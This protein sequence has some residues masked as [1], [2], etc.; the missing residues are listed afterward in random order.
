[1]LSIPTA[2]KDNC[3]QEQMDGAQDDLLP[4]DMQDLSAHD[5]DM[6]VTKDYSPCDSETEQG[7]LLHQQSAGSHCPEQNHYPPN[8]LL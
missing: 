1:M 6:S 4:D 3:G 2:E 7:P 5:E 8:I